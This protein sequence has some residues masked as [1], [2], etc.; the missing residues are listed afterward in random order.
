MSPKVAKKYRCKICDYA[1]RNK[2]DWKKHLS[3][4]KHKNGN[5]MVTNG[6]KKSPPLLKFKCENCEKEYKFRSGLCRHKKKCNTEG[7]NHLLNL[8]T[9]KSP[10]DN[11]SQIPNPDNENIANALKMLAKTMSRQESILEKLVDSQKEMIPCIGN[12]NNNKISINIFLNEKCKDAMNLTDFVK[13][14]KI[15]MEDLH[16]T[17]IH[18]YVKGISNIFQKNLTD[19]KAT[20]RPIHCSDTKRLQF[21]IKEEDKWEKDISHHKI[22]DGINKVGKK[23][24]LQIKEWEKKHPNFLEYEEQ[25]MEWNKMIASIMGGGTE[26]AREKNI[27]N[28]KRTICEKINVKDALIKN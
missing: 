3:T 27:V 19:L 8:V 25:Y 2:F 1:C 26:E 28:I 15:S 4:T 17:N 7:I 23:Q 18:G 10:D 12:N 22:N 20:E 24:I 6:N 21:Y 16:Y 11:V 9:E 13:N 14:I 5:K